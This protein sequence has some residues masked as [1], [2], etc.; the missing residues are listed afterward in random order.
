MDKV[1]TWIINLKSNDMIN[2]GNNTF[3]TTINLPETNEFRKFKIHVKDF[4]VNRVS[5]SGTDCVYQL[6]SSFRFTNSFDTKFGSASNTLCA[7][8]YSLSYFSQKGWS[9]LEVATSINGKITLWI[10][11]S[12]G[13]I[14]PQQ[15]NF[16]PQLNGVNNITNN[17][18]SFYISIVV[19][20]C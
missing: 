7:V 14:I 17:Y 10:E 20:G 18:V 19:I 8:P 6:N 11:G 12:D 4:I 2:N 3:S 5:F 15:N 16:Q 13:L 9:H 1:N